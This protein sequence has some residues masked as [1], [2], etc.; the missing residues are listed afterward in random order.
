MTVDLPALAVVAALLLPALAAATWA[1]RLE[2]RPRRAPEPE[3]GTGRTVAGVQARLRGE[4]AGHRPATG[5]PTPPTPVRRR[6]GV[7]PERRPS[8]PP[9][10]RFAFAAPD[11]ALVRR[12]IDGLRRLD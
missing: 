1:I 12:I 6:R 2:R 8:P 3:A 10:A 5:L 7:A 11:A 9:V 4:V